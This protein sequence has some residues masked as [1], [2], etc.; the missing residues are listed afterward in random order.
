ML[1]KQLINIIRQIF[2]IYQKYAFPKQTKEYGPQIIAL[3]H[4]SENLKKYNF[5]YLELKK[6]LKVKKFKVPKNTKLSKIAYSFCNF[7][8]FDEFQLNFGLWSGAK[9]C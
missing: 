5:G 1:K 7:G 6:N 2:G 9:V 3:I 8:I 4:I